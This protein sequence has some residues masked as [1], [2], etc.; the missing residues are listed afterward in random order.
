MFIAPEDHV[1]CNMDYKTLEV[2]VAAMLANDPEMKR[3]FIMGEDFHMNTTRDVFKEDLALLEIWRLSGNVEA[4]DKYLHK[5]MML[6]IRLA[7]QK[8]IY[9]M[10]RKLESGSFEYEED[11]SQWKM[12]EDINFGKL[13]DLI[14]DYLRFLTKFI[15]FGIMYGRKA[16]S[17]ANGELNCSVADAQKYINAFYRK[18]AGFTAWIKEQEQHAIKD[19]Y[20]ETIFGHRRRW[21]FITSDLLYTIKNQAVNTPIQGSAAQICLLTV[22][23]VHEE[24][25]KTTQDHVLF[26]VHDSLVSELKRETTFQSL[27]IIERIATHPPIETDLPFRVDLE[28]GP[29]YG[30][31]EGITYKNGLWVPSKPDKAS[32]WLKEVLRP[33]LTASETTL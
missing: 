27:D 25:K 5:S 22:V 33:Q 26:T 15:T 1:I 2:V 17:L 8:Y 4:F 32:P 18:Y 21:P 7:G 9:D 13:E 11:P 30:R 6:E 24:F 28:I 23:N 16:P 29:S 3:P 19:G 20:V 31:V 12:R 10:G 14:V